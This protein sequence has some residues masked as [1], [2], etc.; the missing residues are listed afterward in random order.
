VKVPPFFIVVIAN[1]PAGTF[2][3][4]LHGVSGRQADCLDRSDCEKDSEK[5]QHTR[6]V[7][8]LQSLR[9]PELTCSRGMF[10]KESIPRERHA[11]S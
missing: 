4:A 1:P 11:V 7:D 5:K 2:P 6:H 8:V 10:P 9:R 3:A